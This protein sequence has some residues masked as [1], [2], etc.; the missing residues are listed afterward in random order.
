MWG[1]YTEAKYGMTACNLF[2]RRNQFQHSRHP[3]Q[4][5]NFKDVLFS[6]KTK[7]KMESN[8]CVCV[9]YL[10]SLHNL[11]KCFTSL[12]DNIELWRV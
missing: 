3:T 11:L 5:H 4:L 7:E 12:A 9:H 6:Y 2:W 10:T 1:H 8:K